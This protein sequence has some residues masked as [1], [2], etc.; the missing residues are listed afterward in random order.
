MDVFGD[1]AYGTGE[2]R[3][4]LGA[5]GHTAVIKPKPLPAV[6]KGGFTVDDFTVN[7]AAGTATC[8]AG[9]TRP[10]SPTRVVTFGAACHHCPLRQRCTTSTT[11]RKL[12]LHPHDRLLRRARRDWAEDPSLREAYN[13]YRPNVERVIAQIATRGGRR[14]KLRY[15]G[16]AKNDFW[17]HLRAASLNLRRLLSLGLTRQDAAWALT[18]A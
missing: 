7:A 16:T 6:V 9:V 12:V 4:A 13:T 15:I 1:S 8:P 17:L 2:L 14:L 5:A 10:V 3:A 11:G 18:A